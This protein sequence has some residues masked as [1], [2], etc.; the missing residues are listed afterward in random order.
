MG[1]YKLGYLKDLD[2]SSVISDHDAGKAEYD[3]FGGVVLDLDSSLMCRAVGRVN[4]Y[5]FNNYI[6]SDQIIN[7]PN[8]AGTT[9]AQAESDGAFE[10]DE[11][12]NGFIR[13]LTGTARNNVYKILDTY[14]DGRLYI[15]GNYNTDG[16]VYYDYFEVVSGAS[17]F[18]FPTNRNPN[19]Q[20]FK[21][22][23]VNKAVRLPFTQGGLT[24]F[25]G[26][27]PDDFT[28]MSYLTTRNDADRLELM[29][30]HR[31]DYMGFDGHYAYD[32][33]PGAGDGIAPMI[34]ETGDH[35]IENQYLVYMNDYKII[36]DSK[37]NDD[38]TEILIHFLNYSKVIYRGV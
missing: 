4:G 30:N 19:N 36:R 21:R 27:Q 26:Y 10:N 3:K 33:V 11:F 20:V 29:L 6:T 12:N 7:Y 38:F 9:F 34:F 24:I 8:I 32:T 13:F 15:D 2:N 18:E 23:V 22:G 14:A 31:L 37:Y 5:S 35:T 25:E 16:V 17:T 28:L 1:I